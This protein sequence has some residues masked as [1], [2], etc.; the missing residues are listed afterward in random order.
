M[1]LY[2]VNIHITSKQ[3]GCLNLGLLAHQLLVDGFQVW[4]NELIGVLGE[5]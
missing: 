2:H 3:L 5:S 1:D 4:G